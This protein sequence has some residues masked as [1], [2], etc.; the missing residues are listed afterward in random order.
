MLLWNHNSFTVNVKY[1]AGK[2]I[3]LEFQNESENKRRVIRS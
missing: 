3:N 2:K 1:M